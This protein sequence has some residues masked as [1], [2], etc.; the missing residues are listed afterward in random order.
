[1]KGCRF[2]RQ[3]SMEVKDITWDNFEEFTSGNG[4]TVLLD[5]YTVWCSPCKM[6]SEFVEEFASR[7]PEIAVGKVDAEEEEELSEKFGIVSVP[8]LIILE[9]GE[10]KKRAIGGRDTE[11]IEELFR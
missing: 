5:F 1:M 2:T 3:A 6:M 7:H 11:E 9:N 10:E 4:K 8:T